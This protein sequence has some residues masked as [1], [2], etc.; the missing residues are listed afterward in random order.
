VL[1]FAVGI[2]IGYFGFK[3]LDNGT[4]TATTT[5]T[6]LPAVPLT[7][8]Q[9]EAIDP[10]PGDGRENSEDVGNI[11]DVDPATTWSTESYV[12]ADLGG[13]GGVGLQFTLDA[14]QTV[15]ALEVEVEAG[16]WNASVFLSDAPF[17]ST[18]TG[19]PAATGVD[20][21]TT[22]LLE[23]TPPAAARYVL[24]WITS[25]PETGPSGNP[26]RLTITGARVLGG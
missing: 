2:G 1:L 21:G 24:L 8:T 10:S 17:E 7:V 20:L 22:T 13:K 16:P 14:P 6:T 4:T 5:T 11:T 23:M 18:P 3:V 19:A 15:R 25:L 26:Y 9:V 12:S